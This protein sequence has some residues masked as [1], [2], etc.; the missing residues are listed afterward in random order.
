MAIVVG[1]TGPI[2]SGK[3]I[4]ADYL[5]EKG[6]EYFSLSDIVRE[7]AR[8]KGIAI[9]R[10]S[11]QDLGNKLRAEGGDGVLAERTVKKLSGRNTVI[12]SIRN[13]GEVLVLRKIPGF[14]LI[15]VDADVKRRFERVKARSRESDPISYE[16]FLKIEGRDL[17]KNEP[18]SGQQ[19]KKC[20]EMADIKIVN[21]FDSVEEFRKEIEKVF[22]KMNTIHDLTSLR[23]LVKFKKTTQEIKDELRKGWDTG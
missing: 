13:P 20:V 1:L 3:G 22:D 23:G 6:F 15:A 19:V 10:N 21:D 9:E 7:E 5:K 14:K 8:K 4:V 16:Q 2:G 17:G 18:L 12:D 11:L